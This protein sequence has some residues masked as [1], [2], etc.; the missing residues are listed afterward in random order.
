MESLRIKADVLNSSNGRV[1]EVDVSFECSAGTFNNG[2]K[3]AIARTN[4]NG[5]AFVYYNWPYS[6][7]DSY[8]WFGSD[9]VEHTGGS[10]LLT[11]DSSSFSELDINSASIFQT[12]KTVSLIYII[13]EK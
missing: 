6:E 9:K 8:V 1:K 13:N 10:T 7:R 11:V 12:L 4:G 3:A 2:D 5:E